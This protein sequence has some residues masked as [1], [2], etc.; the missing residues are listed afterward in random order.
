LIV[1]DFCD[2]REMLTEYLSFRGFPVV[3]VST[4]EAALTQARERRPGLILMDIQMPGIDG[5]EATRQLKADFVT[6]D[7][8]IVAVT[9]RAL[10]NEERDARRAGCDA[11]VAKPFE[12]QAVGD[13]VREVLVR[14]PLGL[15]AFEALRSI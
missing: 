3:Q 6:Q 4:G 2:G 7:I 1:D 9:A 15:S 10:A 14:G 12:I 8:L 11:S 13:A 5:L